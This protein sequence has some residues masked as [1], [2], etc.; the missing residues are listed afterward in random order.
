MNLVLMLQREA[1]GIAFKSGNKILLKGAAFTN[2]LENC[3][4]YGSRR[5]II[6]SS[7]GLNT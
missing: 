5:K 2:P 3:E 6:P 1:G 7:I 4:A